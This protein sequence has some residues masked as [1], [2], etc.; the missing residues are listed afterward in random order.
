MRTSNTKSASSGTP[1]LKAKL[2]NTSVRRFAS[3]APVA[4]PGAQLRRA[5]LAGVDD[6]RT[7]RAAG[8]QFALEPIASTRRA[9]LVAQILA[10]PVRRVAARSRR[11][12]GCGRRVSEK[13]RT[14]A[15]VLASRN[16]AVI[17]T[18]SPRSSSSSGSRCG[19]EPARARPPRPRRCVKRVR[20]PGAETRAAA[21]AAGC[22]RRRSRRL[23]ARAAPPTCPAGDAGDPPHLAARVPAGRV[24]SALGGSSTSRVLSAARDALRLARRRPTPRADRASP[25]R[26]RAGAGQPL[27]AQH[28][29]RSSAT[30]AS[31]VTGV[32]SLRTR[33][34]SSQLGDHEVMVGAG[35]HLRQV[36]HRQHLAVATSQLLHQAADR[37][38]QPRRRRRSISSKIS[39]PAPSPAAWLVVTRDRQR[40]ARQLAARGHLGQRPRRAAGVAGDEEL[41]G[42]PARRTAALPAAARPRSGRRPCRAAASPA[43]PRRPAGRRLGAAPDF[44]ASVR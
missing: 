17:A 42:L 12:T 1:C 35:R 27:A 3:R 18:P 22:R 38:G 9:A 6:G 26:A 28:A 13:R 23:P 5:Q 43:S 14:S 25:A 41:R 39:V 33:P 21:R 30:C 2:S 16:S 34:L 19:S 11:T 15:S 31:P 10:A 44:A 29:R 37:L 8:Q 24:H 7:P 36:R 20:V 40:D 32:T 4:H